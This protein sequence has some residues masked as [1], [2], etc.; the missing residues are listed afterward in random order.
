MSNR[1]QQ[2]QTALVKAWLVPVA[3]AGVVV[4]AVISY[5]QSPE[6]QAA[7]DSPYYGKAVQEAMTGLVNAGGAAAP[8]A[9]PPLPAGLSPDDYY[10]CE[11]HKTYHPHQAGQ[12]G[13]PLPA[14]AA[15]PAAGTLPAGVAQPPGV[16]AQPAAVGSPPAAQSDL[17]IPPLLAGVSP[18]DYF[19]CDNCKVFHK[20]SEH[21]QPP[22]AG[23][24]PA[25]PAG[26][27]AAAIP[28]LPAGFSPND[29]YWC[30]EHKAYHPRQAAPVSPA[31]GVPTPAPTPTPPPTPAPTP[32]PTPTPTPAPTPAPAPPPAPTL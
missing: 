7:P 32:A 30:A 23:G 18:T 24:S 15:Q 12:P 8:A 13:Q 10:W 20:T 25:N 16:A 4:A 28:P 26:Q 1:T 19:W 9:R 31:A 3:V 14:G 29:Y 5:V 17:T 27:P 22:A 6:M 2:V 21:G 11:E